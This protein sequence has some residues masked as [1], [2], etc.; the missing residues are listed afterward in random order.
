[1][2]VGQKLTMLEIHSTSVTFMSLRN[3]E[4]APEGK[5]TRGTS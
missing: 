2:S 1:M 4:A 3:L 5:E